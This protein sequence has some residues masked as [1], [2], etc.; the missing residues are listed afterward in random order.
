MAVTIK[1]RTAPVPGNAPSPQRSAI[2]SPYFDLQSSIEV[3]DTV[4]KKGGGTC[5]PD[6]LAA[7]MGYKSTSSGTYLTRVSAA[8]RHFGLIET[9][10]ETI[11]VT[12]RA[13]KIL[14]PVMP[15]DALQAKVEAF[16]AVP[17]FARVYEQ[18]RGNALPPEVGLRNLFLTSYRILPDRVGP[19]VRVFLSS[20]EQAGFFTTTG[21]RSRLVKPTVMQSV[22][23]TGPAEASPPA[24]EALP[25][26]PRWRDGGGNGGDGGGIHAALVGLLRELPK[27]GQGW[28]KAEQEDFIAAFTGLIKFIF[29]AEK[30]SRALGRG[31]DALLKDR[32]E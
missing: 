20:A 15:E 28:T 2:T 7:W 24:P 19:A 25:E 5:S 13:R 3:A 22:A 9:T 27:Q 11:T 12:D 23:P 6:Q 14:T 29:P 17:L 4:Y 18:F 16:L 26:A 10:P 32:K 8:Q 31:L 30:D 1:P 21:D